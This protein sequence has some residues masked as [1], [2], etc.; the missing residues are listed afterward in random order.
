MNWIKTKELLPRKHFR[1]MGKNTE[2]ES[3]S[4]IDGDNELG[5]PSWCHKGW[6]HA[7]DFVSHWR[8]LYINEVFTGNLKGNKIAWVGGRGRF[9]NWIMETYKHHKVKGVFNINRFFFIDI[10]DNEIDC[11]ALPGD[12]RGRSKFD[13]IL[14]TENCHV[15][16]DKDFINQIYFQEHLGAEIYYIIDERNNNEQG[17]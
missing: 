11:L 6:K 17:R 7:D 5:K 15:I 10:D 12:F 16:D 3:I 2:C 4:W 1:V 13:M 8:P 9:K 14:I